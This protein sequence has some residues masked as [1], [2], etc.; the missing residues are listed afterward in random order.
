MRAKQ[1]EIVKLAGNIIMGKAINHVIYNLAF[2]PKIRYL[3][4]S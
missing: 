1:M 3:D 2:S 4:L